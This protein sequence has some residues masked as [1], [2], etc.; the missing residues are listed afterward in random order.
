MRLGLIAWCVL[1]AG[2]IGLK[3]HIDL[4]AGKYRD[5]AVRAGNAVY[6]VPRNL[7]KNIDGWRADL[8]RLSGCWDARE[9]GV[10]MAAASFA[11]CAEPQA[12]Q[13]DLTRLSRTIDGGIVPDGAPKDFALWRN[14]SVPGEHLRELRQAWAGEGAWMNRRVVGKGDWQLF[15]IESA[16]APWIYLLSAEPERSLDIAPYYAGRCFRPDSTGDLGMSCSF[17]SHLGYGVALEYTL[18]ADNLS[19]F[20]LIRDRS[21]ALVRSWRR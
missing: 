18:D 7:V 1:G 11:G 6:F 9:N 20:P 17:V 21:A 16:G 12:L 14:Y 2:L 4:T 3:A 19:R 8:L 10:V 13:L 15:R 5:V